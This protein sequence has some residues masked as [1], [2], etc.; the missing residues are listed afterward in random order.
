MIKLFQNKKAQGLSLTT[1]VVAAMALIVLV[2]L[3]AIFTG[4]I[5]SFGQG[6]EDV[7]GAGDCAKTSVTIDD[8]V[9][10]CAWVAGGTCTVAQNNNKKVKQIYTATDSANHPGQDCCCKAK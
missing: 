4:R 5:G 2:V 1:I 10:T 7:G 8:K 3:V 6:V 9:V